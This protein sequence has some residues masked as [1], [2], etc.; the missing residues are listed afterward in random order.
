MRKLK[1]IVL[2]Q[3]WRGFQQQIEHASVQCAG[4]QVDDAERREL[5]L[6]EVKICNRR[7]EVRSEPNPVE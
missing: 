7:T 1:A 3:L 6:S 4:K 2:C 5:M